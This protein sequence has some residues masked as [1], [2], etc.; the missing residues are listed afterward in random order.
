MSS[1]IARRRPSNTIVAFSFSDG[2]ET[3]VNAGLPP[4]IEPSFDLQECDLDSDFDGPVED[5]LAIEP[6]SQASPNVPE[7]PQRAV[8]AYLVKY[9]AYKTL[10]GESNK[11]YRTINK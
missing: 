6:Q 3:D 4:G 5:D 9:T 7:S 2:I 10:S 8:K 1:R 11:V